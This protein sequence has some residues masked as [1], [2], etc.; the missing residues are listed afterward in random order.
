MSLC[1]PRTL[2]DPDVLSTRALGTASLLVFYPL[3]FLQIVEPRFLQSRMMEENVAPFA[4][5]KTITL[6]CQLLNRTFWHFA[7]LQIMNKL[8]SDPALDRRQETYRGKQ[9]APDQGESGSP[10]SAVQLAF[11]K[12]SRSSEETFPGGTDIFFPTRA[13]QYP[14]SRSGQLIPESTEQI[15]KKPGLRAARC[16]QKLRSCGPP[17][18]TAAPWASI[19]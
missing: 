7:N 8:S 13:L 12:P 10:A 2:D 6:V 19:I 17:S 11:T 15:A 3:A 14:N 5:D 4:F 1:G 16:R 9:D 18:L